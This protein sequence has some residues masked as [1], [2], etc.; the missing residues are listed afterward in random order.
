[1]S[2]LGSISP[3]EDEEIS[4]AENLSAARW[5][6]FRLGTG[7]S[8]TGGASEIAPEQDRHLDS[9]VGGMQSLTIVRPVEESDQVWN[10]RL[11]RRV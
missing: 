3:G 7:S 1:M 11:A 6:R 9:I 10:V 5:F 4:Q 2:R 8:I